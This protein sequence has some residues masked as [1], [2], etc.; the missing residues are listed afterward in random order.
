MMP[1]C[2]R[3]QSIRCLVKYLPKEDHW[4]VL[5]EQGFRGQVD[6]SSEVSGL[7]QRHEACS[8]WEETSVCAVWE[9]ISWVQPGSVLGM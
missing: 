9:Q 8:K 7:F 3:C 5:F 6:Q 1:F 2:A 4:R